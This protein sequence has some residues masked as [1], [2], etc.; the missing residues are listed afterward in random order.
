M[1][2]KNYKTLQIRCQELGF[3]SYDRYLGSK[4]WSQFKEAYR[5]NVGERHYCLNCKSLDYL[6]HHL[7]YERLGSELFSDVMALCHECHDLLH[8]RMKERKRWCTTV[9]QAMRMFGKSER[10]RSVSSERIETVKP[11]ILQMS[12]KEL[13]LLRQWIKWQARHATVTALGM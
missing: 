8:H 9:A 7:S 6:L 3:E 11:I 1:R 5:S 10:I 13:Q 4:H 2:G 12:R